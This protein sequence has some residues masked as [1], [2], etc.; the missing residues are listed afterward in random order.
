MSSTTNARFSAVACTRRLVSR[1]V[2][3]R[4]IP[5]GV[6]DGVEDQGAEDA[7]RGMPRE[8][9]GVRFGGTHTWAR[10]LSR[11]ACTNGCTMASSRFML[12]S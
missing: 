9:R 2:T 4:R 12:S 3:L 5:S 10:N 1:L 7:S 11:S 6:Q 8:S